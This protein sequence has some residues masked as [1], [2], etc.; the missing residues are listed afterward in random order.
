[1]NALIRRSVRRLRGYVPGEQPR[2]SGLVKLNT[3]ENPYP[4]SP[5]VAAALAAIRAR[6]LRL[7]PDPVSA[8]LRRRIAAIHRCRAEQVF[9][10]NGSDEVLA[11]CTRAFVEDDG[12]IGFFE[13]SYSLYPVL[14]GI[15]NVRCAPVEL[16]R[17][18]EWAMPEAYR[19]SLFFMACPNAPTGVQYPRRKIAA[20]CR[21]LRGVVVIDE[22][23]A[24]FAR[25]NCM[26]L[27][28]SLPN[29]LVLRTLSKSFSLAGLRLGYAVGS[30]GL[31][32]ALFRIKDSYNVDRLT[33]TVALAA[34]QDL[35]HMRSNAARIRRTRHRLATALGRRGFT[36]VPSEANFLWTKP[37]RVPARRLFDEL[38]KKGI[39]VRHFPGRRTG[40]YLRITVGSDNEVDALI[41]AIS[42]QPGARET[43][44]K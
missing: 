3:N 5:K 23:Y 2:G 38:R 44:N 21:R 12:T 30:E 37:P 32:S 9:V 8:R 43:R 7:Y 19:C 20:F 22:A 16:G 13:P 31:I 18:F 24:G 41:R 4:P 36:V 40:D 15:R 29:T 6:D 26:D 11:L 34:L 17:D 35:R 14:A 33:Q 28:L 27:A 1:M 39:L 42:S 10:G 25:E